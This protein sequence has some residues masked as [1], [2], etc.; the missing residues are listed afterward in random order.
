[1]HE[2][3]IAV[4]RLSG[5]LDVDL[6]SGR[7]PREVLALLGAISEAMAIEEGGGA[8]PDELAQTITHRRN[9]AVPYL[10]R[11]PR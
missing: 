1:M 10:A 8:V 5:R 11:Q 7:G 9:A 4:E 3:A 6:K 2:W